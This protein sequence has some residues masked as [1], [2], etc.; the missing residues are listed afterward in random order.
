MSLL[1]P[2]APVETLAGLHP[3]RTVFAPR[4]SP[5]RMQWVVRDAFRLDALTGLLVGV[6]G[7]MPLLCHR[8]VMTPSALDCYRLGGL[9]PGSALEGY[10]DLPE[11]VALARAHQRRGRR[12]AYLYPPP[13]E[14]AVTDGL[15]VPVPLYNWLN[16][17]ANLDELVPA[18]HLPPGCQFSTENIAQAMQFLPGQPVFVKACHAGASGGGRG[19]RHCPDE[20]SR[21][22]ALEEFRGRSSELTAVRVEACVELRSCWCLSLAVQPAGVR[23]LGAATQLF[24]APGQQSGSRICPDDV[25][26]ERTVALALRIADRARQLGYCGVAGFDVGET[27]AGRAVVFDLNFRLAAST[28]QVLLH[29]PATRRVGGRVSQS[30]SRQLVAPLRGVLPLLAPFVEAG[31]WVPL[32]LSEAT[33]ASGGRC[34]ITGLLIAEDVPAVARLERELQTALERER[35]APA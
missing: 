4:S 20:A 3:P 25:P 24:A 28:P 16:D 9:E 10:E 15:L 1:Q 21:A 5:D 6:A 27:P 11:F 23:H 31:R 2:L 19:V 34:V 30:W 7:D 29:E 8:S 32:R 14:L 26:G 17:R 22:R 35:I 33:P 13:E 18:E 12:L